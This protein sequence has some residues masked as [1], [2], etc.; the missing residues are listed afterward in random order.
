MSSGP[1]VAPAAPTALR[2]R[3]VRS[4]RPSVAGMNL[5]GPLRQPPK[6]V[7]TNGWKVS[8]GSWR[9]VF[10][11]PRPLRGTNTSTPG[12]EEPGGGGGVTPPCGPHPSHSGM[13]AMCPFSLCQG[14]DTTVCACVCMH[15]HMCIR[16]CWCVCTFA[17]VRVCGY[18]CTFACVCTCGA[19]E[20]ENGN[21][22]PI[23]LTAKT[24]VCPSV[25]LGGSHLCSHQTF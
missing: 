7:L 6:C 2:E 19:F 16:V 12:T 3:A 24:P 1:S 10:L 13:R 4:Q 18:M 11:P 15:A 23:C 25:G 14:A 17:R 20:P 9:R 21:R 8:L 22:V 5:H